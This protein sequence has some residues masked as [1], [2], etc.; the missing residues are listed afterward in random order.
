MSV[1]SFP[2]PAM[3]H[4]HPQDSIAYQHYI[5][6]LLGYGPDLR[7]LF[8][9][10][11]ANPDCAL[12]QANGAALHLAF[13]A[14][15]GWQ[16]AQSYLAAMDRAVALAG[17]DLSA[18][19]FLFCAAVRAWAEKDW[20]EALNFFKQAIDADPLDVVALKWG[21][22][23]AFNLGDQQS[24]LTLGKS[25]VATFPEAPYVRGMLAFALEQT[26]QYESAE[27]TALAAVEIALDDAW[28][29]HAIAH[30][31]ESTGRAAEGAA[32]L[33]RCA[34]IWDSKGVFIREHNWWHLALFHLHL[35]NQDRV[36]EIYDQHL[37]GEWPE[38]PQ[39]QIGAA[40]ML[41]RMQLSGIEGRERWQPILEQARKRC[42][43]LLYPFHH[44]HYLFALAS[45]GEKGEAEAHLAAIERHAD[46]G[47]CPGWEAAVPAARG[48]VAFA[49][50]DCLTASHCLN[51]ALP[52]LNA[53]GGSHAQRAIFSD[54]LDVAQQRQASSLSK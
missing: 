14:S 52:K 42:D 38:F 47:Q 19:E 18:N 36:L 11:D 29:H 24:L 22:Y 30:V 34:H 54:T 27:A 13:E 48:I 10:A 20:P 1:H 2:L 21:Q 15:E 6:Q 25:A 31:M 4:A 46:D 3:S 8:T 12:L 26:Y 51:E 53:I 41:W 35:G 43:D 16:M 44:L 9:A 39:E 37:W 28:A 33:E 7:D 40:S 23:H 5:G 49:R 45:A 50:G 17:K 32:W